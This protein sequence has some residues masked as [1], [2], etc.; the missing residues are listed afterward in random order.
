M[1]IEHYECAKSTWLKRELTLCHVQLVE[2]KMDAKFAGK[3]KD[4]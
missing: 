4:A 1:S 3:R 2:I